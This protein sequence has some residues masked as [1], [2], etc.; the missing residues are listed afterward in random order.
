MTSGSVISNNGLH[1]VSTI[2]TMI[3]CPD[4]TIVDSTV[5]GNGTDAVC[6]VAETCADVAACNLPTVT[7]TTCNTSYD[8]NSGFPGTSWGVC[9]LD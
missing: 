3:E 4:V 2:A 7:N 9:A 5:T 6:G 1:G 8:V